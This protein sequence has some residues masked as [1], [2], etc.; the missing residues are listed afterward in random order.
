MNELLQG[1]CR[2]FG[3]IITFDPEVMG[4]TGRTLA[5]SLSSC[6]IATVFCLP[7]AG[8]VH[9][10]SF[11]GKR[12]LI[13]IVQT[14]YSMP[15]VVVGLLIFIFFSGMG[16]LG[17]FNLMYTPAIMVIGQVV[18]ISPVVF[19]LTVSAL[20]S[21]DRAVADTARSLGASGWQTA[22]LVMREARFA[23]MAAVIMGFGRAIS[24]VGLALMVGGN[25]RGYT[26]VL[27]TAIAQETS[28]GD[29]EMAIALGIILV[30]IALAVN[31]I[32]NRIQQSR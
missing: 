19:G 10:K 3:L 15:T 28:Q 21:V 18:L 6:L 14:F 9:F 27:T 17:I 12:V 7:L 24:E 11:I 20:S 8:L 29:V 31:I 5:I 13:N 16:P 32:M 4:I 30:I 23:V 25:I 2:A 1:F 26:Q 22:R